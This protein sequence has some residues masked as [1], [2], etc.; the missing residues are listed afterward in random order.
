MGVNERV[1]AYAFRIVIDVL[2][3]CPM[4]DCISFQDRVSTDSSGRVVDRDSTGVP[5]GSE[6]PDGRVE[7]DGH[8]E[9]LVESPETEVPGERDREEGED[10]DRERETTGKDDL[11]SSIQSNT[12]LY[13]VRQQ[14]SLS[15][16]FNLGK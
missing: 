12:S 2:I 4:L 9:P 16:H 5:I 10:A 15:I 1:C 7:G 13:T 3:L 8:R 11:V 14:N 6:A